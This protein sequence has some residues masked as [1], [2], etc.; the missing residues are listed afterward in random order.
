M[1]DIIKGINRRQRRE[2]MRDKRKNNNRAETF[3]RRVQLVPAYTNEQVM[4]GK[5]S[6]EGFRRA[7]CM[8]NIRHSY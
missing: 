8:R 5:S 6:I 4:Q 7:R 2:Q 1:F 3:A